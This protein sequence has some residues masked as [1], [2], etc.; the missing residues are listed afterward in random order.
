MPSRYDNR[1][2]GMNNLKMYKPLF[3]KRGIRFLKQYKSPNMHAPTDRELGTLTVQSHIWKMGDRYWK[4]ASTYYQDPTLWWIIAWFNE[5]PTESHVKMGEVIGIPLPY[6]T[7]LPI[8]M[9][10]G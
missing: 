2:A 5:K 10:T 9:R 6:D 8:L 7:I 3:E 4:L 1:Y